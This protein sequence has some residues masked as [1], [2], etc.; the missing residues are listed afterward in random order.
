MFPRLPGKIILAPMAGVT[1]IAF[2]TLCKRYGAALTVTEFVSADAILRENFKTL[3]MI[4]LEEEG[5]CSIQ[6]FG[7]DVRKIVEAAKICAEKADIVDFNL[8]CPAPHVVNAGMGSALLEDE[9]QVVQIVSEVS[10]GIKKPFTVKLRAGASKKAINTVQ[11]AKQ[12]ESAGASAICIHARTREE[13]YS[14]KADWSLIKQIK[15]SV[16]IPVIGN[17]DVRSPEAALAMLNETDCDYVMVGRGAIGNPLIFQQCNDFFTKGFYQPTKPEDKTRVFLEYLELAERYNLD[18][19]IKRLQAQF[20][21]KG[22]PNSSRL[23][24]LLNKVKTEE[25]LKKVLMSFKCERDAEAKVGINSY[26]H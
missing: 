20:F 12:I 19:I 18:F 1:D 25:E 13:G 21:T 9:D 8:G 26:L 2:R 24:L 7:C 3:Q 15:A 23:R 16:A 10:K 6:I 11:L 14:G 5:L 4:R 17:G 22:L